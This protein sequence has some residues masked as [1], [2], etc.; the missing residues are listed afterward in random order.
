[1]V[2]DILFLKVDATIILECTPVSDISFLKV[3]ATGHKEVLMLFWV[4]DISFLTIK[5]FKMIR[6]L[7]KQRK[8]RVYSEKGKHMG[9]YPS[10][11]QAEKRLRQVEYFKRKK[12]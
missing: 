5:N 7:P 2:S 8:W 12:K 9:T 1:M 3:D 10:R 4:S 6:K 11:K